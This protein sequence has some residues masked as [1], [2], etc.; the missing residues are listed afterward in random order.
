MKIKL[1]IVFMFIPVLLW[2]QSYEVTYN[3]TKRINKDLLPF[4]TTVKIVNSED[5]DN[6]I[7]ALFK[8]LHTSGIKTID[9]IEIKNFHIS[10]NFS[11][12]YDYFYIDAIDEYYNIIPFLWIEYKLIE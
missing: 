8:L 12:E 9:G 3:I 2:S 6:I 4:D 5:G 11:Y 7:Q 1:F 10:C